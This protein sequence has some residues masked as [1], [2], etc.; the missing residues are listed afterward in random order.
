VTKLTDGTNEQ[1]GDENVSSE[2]ERDFSIIRTGENT[3][4]KRISSTRSLR[5]LS[6]PVDQ[7]AGFTL[8]NQSVSSA[9]STE[10]FAFD[11]YEREGFDQIMRTVAGGADQ[12]Q[13]AFARSICDYLEIFESLAAGRY[14]YLTSVLREIVHTFN[15]HVF[16]TTARRLAIWYVVNRV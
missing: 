9:G 16:A 5:E 8:E 2:R 11:V 3:N 6:E 7:E 13:E 4:V 1:T 14:V 12:E 10:I 15:L